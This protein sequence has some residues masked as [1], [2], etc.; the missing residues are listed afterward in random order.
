MIVNALSRYFDLP[1][2]GWFPENIPPPPSPVIKLDGE[3]K[4]DEDII[5]EAV[6]LTYDI[7]TDNSNLRSSPYDFEN[8]RGDYPLRRE[9]HAYTVKIKDGS[10]NVIRMLKDLGF[11]VV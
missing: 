2:K 7:E 10:K 1:L 4:S 8:Q 5:R 3:G 9:F 11:R 6:N